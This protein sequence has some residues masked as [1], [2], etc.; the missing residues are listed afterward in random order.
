M[1]KLLMWAVGVP[2]LVAGMALVTF[3]GPVGLPGAGTAVAGPALVR[4]SN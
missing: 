3:N 4:T 2:F 1:K